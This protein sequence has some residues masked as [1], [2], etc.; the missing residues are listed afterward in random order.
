MVGPEA[1]GS[2]GVVPGGDGIC[3]DLDGEGEGEVGV[4]DEDVVSW[5]VEML[6]LDRVDPRRRA[7]HL[8]WIRGV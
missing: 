7:R 6:D 8:G 2:G 1:G 4:E 5:S 3:V